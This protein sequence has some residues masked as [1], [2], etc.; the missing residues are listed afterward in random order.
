LRSA[1]LISG[2]ARAGHSFQFRNPSPGRHSA[3]RVPH[4]GADEPSA[5]ASFGDFTAFSIH[6]RAR[7]P[8]VTSRILENNPPLAHR[9]TSL[10]VLRYGRQ[11]VVFSTDRLIHLCHC[12]RAEHFEAAVGASADWQ[13]EMAGDASP[14]GHLTKGKIDGSADQMAAPAER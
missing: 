7:C 13:R 1:R 3:A 10:F 2:S 12:L 5:W 4:A 8:N 11:P 9:Q 14:V 6:E